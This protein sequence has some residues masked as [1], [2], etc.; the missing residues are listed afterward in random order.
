MANRT[1]LLRFG[2]AADIE[3]LA[4]IVP[5]ARSWNRRRFGPG[6]SLSGVEFLS[7]RH[8]ASSH[9]HSSRTTDAVETY[10]AE[11]FAAITR[12]VADDLAFFNGLG[13][14]AEPYP[15]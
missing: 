8:R 7:P 14:F 9:V 6:A 10:S 11:L 15:P 4:T 2:D 12:A 13:L 5:D 1:R 3:S